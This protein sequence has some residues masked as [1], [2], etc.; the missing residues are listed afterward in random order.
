LYPPFLLFAYPPKIITFFHTESFYI[1]IPLE[2][3]LSVP[4]SMQ[5]IGLKFEPGAS[6]SCTL[7]DELELEPGET[8]IV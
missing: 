2:N 7:A 3:P 8:K 5:N 1:E 4:L 6:V